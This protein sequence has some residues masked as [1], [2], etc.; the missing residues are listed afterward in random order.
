MARAIAKD[1]WKY[2]FYDYC[3]MEKV[4]LLYPLMQSEDKKDS[5]I[6]VEEFKD[7]KRYADCSYE[8]EEYSKLF[9]I[10]SK[11]SSNLNEM[12]EKCDRFPY[13]NALLGRP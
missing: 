4:F 11:A 10:L 1:K 7:L 6:F 5:D 12:L 3:I 8:Y 2:K 9:D 13:R